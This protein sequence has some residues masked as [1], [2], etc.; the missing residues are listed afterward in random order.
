MS[1]LR[2]R[3]STSAADM[4]AAHSTPGTDAATAAVAVVVV[5]ASA[6]RP[7][8]VMA[9]VDCRAFSQCMPYIIVP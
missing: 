7:F 5:E 4:G 8:A 3:R 6:G 2:N 1:W 9:A